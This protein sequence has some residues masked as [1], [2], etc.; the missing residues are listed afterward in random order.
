MFSKSYIQ[1]VRNGHKWK[2]K[3]LQTNYLPMLYTEIM[4]VI[5]LGPILITRINFNPRMDK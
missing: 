4:S 1:Y 5:E 3:K 2:I